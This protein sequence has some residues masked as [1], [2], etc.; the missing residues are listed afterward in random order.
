MLRIDKVLYRRITGCEMERTWKE[1]VVVGQVLRRNFRGWSAEY[2]EN[3]RPQDR[4]LNPKSPEYKAGLLSTCLDVQW[5]PL[6]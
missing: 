4:Y 2:H 5:S 3:Y 6:C 1:A